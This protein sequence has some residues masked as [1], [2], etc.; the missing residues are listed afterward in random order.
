LYDTLL[1][2]IANVDFSFI[3]V[4]YSSFE[5]PDSIAYERALFIKKK[6]ID[7][8]ANPN[9]IKIESRSNKFPQLR[10]HTFGIR[11]IDIIAGE[12]RMVS[13]SLL[14]QFYQTNPAIISAFMRQVQINRDL[15]SKTE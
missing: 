11:S 2:D 13:D 10:N 5:E 7:F 14:L 4:G 9:L 8:G 15:T 3:L 12:D 1:T 6:M